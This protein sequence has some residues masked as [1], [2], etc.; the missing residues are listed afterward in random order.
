M[1][2]TVEAAGAPRNVLERLKQLADERC[3][4]VE[5]VTRSIPL[6]TTLA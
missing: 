3:P 2:F 1:K 6:E 4:G 5:C